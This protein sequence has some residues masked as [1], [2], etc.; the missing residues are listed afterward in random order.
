[1]PSSVYTKCP[2]DCL[3]GLVETGHDIVVH[4]KLLRIDYAEGQLP[5]LVSWDIYARYRWRLYYTAELNLRESDFVLP[6]VK[7]SL[8][9][10]KI[11][12]RTLIVLII[13]YIIRLQ[14]EW[15]N[16]HR[17]GHREG[18][19]RLCRKEVQLESE[20]PIR[21][22]N[23]KWIHLNTPP[24]MIDRKVISSKKWPAKKYLD[25][26]TKLYLRLILHKNI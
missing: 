4:P 21:W 8:G 16:S 9:D 7:K 6:G 15:H 3:W 18:F 13:V 14:G 10:H 5:Q 20:S 25:H 2:F 26:D 12:Y 23:V 19:L 1:M 24:T 22:M 11:W 17:N